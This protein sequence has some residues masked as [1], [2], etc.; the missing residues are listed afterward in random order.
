M[1]NIQV[2]KVPHFIEEKYYNNLLLLTS[3]ETREKIK[4]FKQKPDAYRSLLADLLIRSVICNKYRISNDEVKF[5]YNKYG[6]PFYS[7]D[8][9]FFFNLSHSGEWVACIWANFIVGVD[10]EQILPIDLEIATHFFSREEVDVLYGKPHG[11]RMFYFY[12]LWTLKESYIKALGKGMSLPLNSFTITKSAEKGVI[13]KNQSHNSSYYFKQYCVNSNYKLSLCSIKNEF[14][15][16]VT[17]RE[18][19]ELELTK[20]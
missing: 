5:S 3:R 12:D 1:I 13:I 2:I 18:L 15:K 4:R 7:G 19:C 17:Y 6:K 14:P 16:K 11:E 9:N 8:E 20:S 10:I